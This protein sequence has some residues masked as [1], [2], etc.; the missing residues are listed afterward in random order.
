MENLLETKPKYNIG[1]ILYSTYEQRVIKYY[2]YKVENKYLVG[3]FYSLKMEGEMSSFNKVYYRRIEIPEF[4]LD[5][6]FFCEKKDA[7]NK[8]IKEM[9]ETVDDHTRRLVD[10]KEKNK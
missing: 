9:E 5:R 3:F 6:I 10:F 7:V 8:I 2:I 1:D 4:D